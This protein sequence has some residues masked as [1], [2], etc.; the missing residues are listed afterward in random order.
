MLDQRLVV[1]DWREHNTCWLLNEIPQ[2]T[3]EKSLVPICSEMR[4]EFVR[5]FKG[6][7]SKRHFQVRILWGQPTTVVSLGE[8]RVARNLATLPQV[9]ERS[10][11]LCSPNFRIL[12]PCG[13][14]FHGS[15]WSRK[16][17]IRILK[18][19]TWFEVTETGRV[20]THSNGIGGIEAGRRQDFP[21]ARDLQ[22]CLQWDAKRTLKISLLS[23]PFDPNRKSTG[24]CPWL[25]GCETVS[26]L[27][28]GS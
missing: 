2:R 18:L 25:T 12:T 4:G 20:L 22:S 1:S 14:N 8:F 13:K 11:G 9:S 5:H 27:L 16:F 19:E 24:Y 6:H 23:S 15:L 10:I 17:N 7:F 26:Y 28:I 3:R 21:R